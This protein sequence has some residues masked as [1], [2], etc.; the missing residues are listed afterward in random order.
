[1]KKI[2][3]ALG[4]FATLNVNAQDKQVKDIMGDEGM[5]QLLAMMG[6]G[7]EVEPVYTFPATLN[8]VVQGYKNGKPQSPTNLA[9]YI[10]NDKGYFG[11][12]PLDKDEASDML[13]IFKAETGDVV[14]LN[15]KEKTAFA[16]NTS[17]IMQS[18][19]I[20]GIA[21]D[22]KKDAAD[23][24]CNKTGKTKTINGYPCEQYVCEN[25]AKQ[26]RYEMW[27][28][29]KIKIDLLNSMKD[30]PFAIYFS[31]VEN[32]GGMLMQGDFY[33]K[34][35]QVAHIEVKNVNEKANIS[36]KTAGFKKSMH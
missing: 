27:V 7:A 8:M 30:N 15:E 6:G 25:A 16:M 4:L 24:K 33:E 5:Q 31:K 22:S 9:I 32:V 3:L 23:V 35:E 36:I 28:T 21:E 29:N 26:G 17:T 13:M 12:K 11:T 20:K 1:M 10:N 14:M 34:G 18:D 2:L 19:M